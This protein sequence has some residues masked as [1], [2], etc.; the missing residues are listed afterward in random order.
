MKPTPVFSWMKENPQ[1]CSYFSFFLKKGFL[2]HL[3]AYC[4]LYPYM[5][6]IMG[7]EQNL[8]ILQGLL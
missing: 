7:A 3:T 5:G 6:L 1:K 8:G 2:G 4:P